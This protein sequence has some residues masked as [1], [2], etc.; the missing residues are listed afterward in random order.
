[1]NKNIYSKT[2]QK[3]EKIEKEFGSLEDFVILSTMDKSTHRMIV[4]DATFDEMGSV[5]QDLSDLEIADL[6]DYQNLMGS[7]YGEYF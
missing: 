2:M 5:Y 1:M 6:L 7:K 3:V 4:E